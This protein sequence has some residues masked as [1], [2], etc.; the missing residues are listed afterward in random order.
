MQLKTR[1]TPKLDDSDVIWRY[2]SF[3][4]FVRL[5]NERHLW[6][7]RADTFQDQHEARFPP[8]LRE[9]IEKK[10]KEG[11]E[12]VREIRTADDFQR[13]LV[14]NTYISCW[15]GCSE[16]SMV[17]WKLYGKEG[18]AVR[19]TVS[20]LRDSIDCSSVDGFCINL[21][22]VVY[23]S[24]LDKVDEFLYEDSAFYKRRH[25]DFEEEVRVSLDTYKP[26]RPCFETPLGHALPVD[27]SVLVKEVLVHPD[28]DDALASCVQQLLERYQLNVPVSLGLCGDR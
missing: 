24:D 20:A 7:A 4:K 6:L 8:P 14:R 10:F 9:A 1:A 12:L 22:K 26:E 13:V 28:S 11:L 21:G 3:A 17:M 19:S 5:L 27:L 16:E 23:M 25:Y 15:Y 18:L 2:M